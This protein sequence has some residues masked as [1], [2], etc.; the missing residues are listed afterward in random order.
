MANV[1]TC[2]AAPQDAAPTPW[3]RS[4]AS[5]AIL[6]N[7]Q[8]G[9]VKPG[10]RERIV[11]C[12]HAAGIAAVEAAEIDDLD[13][14]FT[15]A[16][17]HDVIIILGGDGTA[18]AAAA[19]APRDA[20]PLILL[21]GG[22]L[23]M[24][25][26][27]LYGDA[28]WPEALEAALRRGVVT[29]LSGG[30]ANGDPFFVAALFGAPALLARAREAA[31][32]GHLFSAMRRFRHFAAR[33]FSNKISGRPDGARMRRS[34]AIGVLCPSFSG[35]PS[36]CDL[37]WVRLDASGFADLTRLGLRALGESWRNDPAVE[38]RRCCGG[39]VH[40]RGIMHATLDGEPRTFLSPVRIVS[41]A[42]GPRVITVPQENAQA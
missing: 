19:R 29:R 9:G 16:R 6:C 3:L 2:D 23:N 20:P 13:R 28:A 8:S 5:A 36:D 10:D 38:A 18:R 30:A 22:T 24:L 41:N 15:S 34:E 32:K 7:E 42:V 14:L 35:T 40:A 17:K 27:T 33:A 37:E 4:G 1:Q 39:E 25:P 26:K 12:A 21:P 11:E 31:R